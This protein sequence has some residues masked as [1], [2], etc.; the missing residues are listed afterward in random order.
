MGKILQYK[1]I[2]DYVKSKNCELLT[3]KFVNSRTKMLF[4][5]Q[6]GNEFET[7]WNSFR[8]RNKITCNN[9]TEKRLNKKN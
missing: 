9:C 5:C 4:R 6:C 1:E 7:T 2:Y 3:K 8:Q